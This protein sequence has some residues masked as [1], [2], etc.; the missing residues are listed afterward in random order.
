MKHTGK[1]SN[2]GAKIVIAYRTLPGD[3][4]SA[5]VIG[6]NNLGDTY[7]DA[8]MNLLQDVS[9]QQANEFADILAVRKFP[10]GSGMLEWLHKRGH[11]KKVPTKLVIVTPNNQ[12]SIPLNE[13]NELIAQ[14][15]GIAVDELAITDGVKPNKK[16]A[17]KDDPTK[18]TSATVNAGEEDDDIELTPVTSKAVVEDISNLTPTQLRSRA[19]KL[20]KEA[21]LL[22]KQADN[23]DPPKKRTKTVETV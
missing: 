5:L 15:K 18:T 9:G 1:M 22:R 2:N 16:I 4:N 3:S 23:I 8:I 13:L 7:H 19:D 14:Q 17:P 11:L 10:D 21:Q 12:T 20:F 6:T